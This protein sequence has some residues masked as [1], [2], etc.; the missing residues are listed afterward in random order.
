[1]QNLRLQIGCLVLLLSL[2]IV[3]SPAAAAEI[4]PQGLQRLR[5]KAAA[6]LR[7]TDQSRADA[8][9]V[10]LERSELLGSAAQWIVD[11]ARRT[12]G[13]SLPVGGREQLK[14]GRGHIV[15]IVG[16]ADP[17][18]KRLAAAGLL[19]LE[20]RV[21]PQGFVI[22]RLR[23]PQSGDLLVCWSPAP[24]GCRYGLIEILRSLTCAGHAV[25]TRLGHVVERPQ[26]PMRICYVNF[27]EHLQNAFNPNVLFDTPVNRWT[28]AEWERF[29]DMASSFRYNIFEFWLVPTLFSPEALHGGK[30]Q[31]QFV[32]T[33]NHVIAYAKRRGVA[34]HPIIANT[35]GQN[36]Q[37]LCP[38]DPK[39]RAELF[40]LW[41]YWSRTMRGNEY[42]GIFPGDPGGCCRNGCTAETFVDMCLDLSKVLQ[43]N[44]PGVKIEVASWG[45]PFAGWGVPLWTGD[46]KRAEKSMRYFLA[47]LPEFPPGMFA[48]INQGF[49]PDCNPT[50]LGNDGRPF[51]KEAAK[52]R[53]V[54]TWD[55]SV[56]EGE[57]TVSPR[58]RVRRMF[59]Q[60]LAELAQGCYSGG[61]CYT[62]APKL[63]CLSIFCCAEAYWN[64]NLKPE[65]VL[66]DF[67]RL[68]FGERRAAIGPL[69]EEFEVIPDWGYYAPF[70]YSPER[71]QKSMAR[72]LP[73][74]EGVSP[75]SKSRLPLAPTM[76]EYRKS[77]S[78]YAD[79]F[80]RLASVALDL[81]QA[82]KLALKSGHIPASRR[83]LLSLADLEETLAAAGDFAERAA[84]SAVAARLRQADV[85]A[86]RKGYAKTVYGIYDSGIPAPVDPRS[87]DA[88]NN[89]FNLFHSDLAMPG[90]PSVLKPLLHATG[91]PYLWIGLGHVVAERGWTLG[92]WG[93]QGDANGVTWRASFDQPGLL[94]RDDFKDQGYRWLVIRLTEGPAGE[95]KTLAV[96]GRVIGRF[97]RTGPAVAVKKEWFVTRS[98]PIPEGLLKDG[99]IEIRFTDPGIAIA[100][101]ALS[102]EPVADS[103]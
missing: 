55:Y 3:P 84:L 101:V 15:A 42:M 35:A 1:M 59:Q 20:P 19:H 13:A 40:A 47:K 79:L 71:L 36:W 39:E 22:E 2:G 8:D 96:N 25:E 69:M 67:G 100:E 43:R 10:L 63:N 4:W 34:V 33:I 58:C 103:K 80:Q 54:L 37:T 56:T 49:N 76:A 41:D 73:M 27:A 11:F 81:E 70:P 97:M 77:L 88:T 94:T 90:S 92:G 28:T 38:N 31:R 51:A 65:G 99:K 57:G 53:P 21:G 85:A 75:E 14:P 93:A 18:G 5:Q 78:Y 66:A 98:Y 83:D 72:L 64:P 24:L 7:L 102:A 52:T 91:K 46:G 23:D 9:I 87:G 29:I 30:I 68:V 6:P 16:D 50:S 61:I 32:E 89:L 74:L 48:S 62:M 95:G 86:L 60:R 17:L 82:R 45:E 26:F 44:N 12:G